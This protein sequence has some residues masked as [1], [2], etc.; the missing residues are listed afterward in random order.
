VAV[1][2]ILRKAAAVAALSCLLPAGCDSDSALVS[3]LSAATDLATAVDLA[4]TTEAVDL[5]VE[6][7]D[8]S[9]M[10]PGPVPDGGAPVLA[11]AGVTTLSQAVD[12]ISCEV[13]EQLLFHIH[14]HVRMYVDGQENLVPAGIGIGPPLQ[15]IGAVVVG[16]S[17]FSWLHTH[18][19]SGIIHVESPVQRTFTLGDFFDIWGQPLSTTQ[20]GPAQG[21]VTAFVNGAPFNGDPRTIALD[22]YAVIQLDIGGPL[23]APQPYVW[24]AGY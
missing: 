3:D 23:I 7:N 17:C 19:E 11:P 24:P 15:M 5:S 12:G 1:R 16:G 8:L 20:A 9:L 21:S 22:S 14:S 10:Q 2:D 18:D 6:P 4:A 13:D